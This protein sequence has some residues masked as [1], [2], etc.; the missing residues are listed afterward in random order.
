MGSEG[1]EWILG[2][3]FKASD[4]N[5]AFS[6]TPIT[7]NLTHVVQLRAGWA[8]N[9]RHAGQAA[10]RARIGL[11]AAPG[12][13]SDR[14]EDRYFTISREGASADYLYVAAELDHQRAITERLTWHA[15]LN[16]QL[17]RDRLIGS[18]QFAAGGNLG[19][20]G[21]AEGELYADNGISLIQE[22]ILPPLSPLSGDDRFNLT[23]FLFLD[24][25]RGWQT[26]SRGDEEERELLS[27]GIG[28]RVAFAP[29]LSGELVHGWQLDEAAPGEDASHTH[30][31]LVFSY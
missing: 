10:T 24:A 4:N 8:G 3:D 12:D 28:L 1:G 7:D 13:L 27:A 5:F 23:P 20:R 15:R 9:W 29:R 26:H 25:A 19:P 17:S 21:Y 2:L 22:L 6:D 18:E 31:S 30:F 16:L 11:V 14:N